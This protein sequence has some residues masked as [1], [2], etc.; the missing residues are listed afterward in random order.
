MVLNGQPPRPSILRGGLNM[1]K[2]F[3]GVCMALL[4]V[5]VYFYFSVQMHGWAPAVV[6]L[7]SAIAVSIWF[8]A[9]LELI[10]SD[11]EQHK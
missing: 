8:F 10:F 7:L 9:A 4:P 1:T 3:I 5:L 6:V 11:N 2:K